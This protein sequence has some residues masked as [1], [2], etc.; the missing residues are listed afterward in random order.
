MEASDQNILQHDAPECDAPSPKQVVN[1]ASTYIAAE[2][3]RNSSD[4]QTCKDFDRKISVE[5]KKRQSGSGTLNTASQHSAQG[6]LVSNENEENEISET[7]VSGNV[8]GK[9]VILIDDVIDTGR[10]LKTAVQVK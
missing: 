3:G 9:R 7:R 4:E 6:N 10:Q 5:R 2:N 1:N 8:L